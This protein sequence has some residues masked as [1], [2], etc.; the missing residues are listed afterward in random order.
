V[1]HVENFRPLSYQYKH[2]QRIKVQV[3][4]ERSQAPVLFCS[5]HCSTFNRRPSSIPS[6]ALDTS[7]PSTIFP[8]LGFVDYVHTWV[9]ISGNF[10]LQSLCNHC[11]SDIVDLSYVHFTKAGH[12]STSVNYMEREVS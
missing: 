7:L 9:T 12:T 1:L 6:R 4:F 3:N 10:S 2:A 5:R 8:T 11:I